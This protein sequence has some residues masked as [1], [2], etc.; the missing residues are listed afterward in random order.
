MWYSKCY[1]LFATSWWHFYIY[2]T[3]ELTYS[4]L[5]WVGFSVSAVPG[6]QFFSPHFPCLWTELIHHFVY[7]S[8]PQVFDRTEKPVAVASWEPVGCLSPIPQSLLLAKCC[9]PALEFHISYNSVCS[10]QNYTWL[11]CQT[12][13]LLVFPKT[14]L[15]CLYFPYIQLCLLR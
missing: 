8:P 2:P 12:S 9:F 10:L 14:A 11:P 4:F 6:S 1:C 13:I 15:K 3:D 5:T 7:G